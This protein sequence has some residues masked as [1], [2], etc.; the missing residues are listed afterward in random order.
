MSRDSRNDVLLE[1]VRIG[2]ED[3]SQ[4]PGP[5][6]APHGLRGAQAAQPGALPYLRERPLGE[7]VR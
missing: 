2:P 5:G 7:P 3:A 6:A 4:P 1:P